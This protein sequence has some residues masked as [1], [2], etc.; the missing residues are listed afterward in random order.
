MNLKSFVLSLLIIWTCSA[1]GQNKEF[2]KFANYQDSLMHKAYNE[3]NPAD[4]LLSLNKFNEEY[5]RLSD[6]DKYYFR[7]FRINAIYNLSCTYSIINDKANALTYLKT[8]FEEGYNDLNHIKKD[9][10]LDNIRHEDAFLKIIEQYRTVYDYLYILK[11]AG[12]YNLQE[13]QE[14]PKFTYQGSG[15]PDLVRL[16]KAFKLDSVA[17]SGN[18]V[19]KIQNILHWV[20]NSIRHDGQHESGIKEVNA[21]AILTAVQTRHIGV[22][23]GEL[24]TVLK[25]CYLAMGWPARKVYCFPKDSLRTDNDSHVI[26]IVYLTSMHKWIWVDPT[27]DA[28]V[29]D[30]NGQLL[31]IEE[32]R[33]RLISDKPL[34]VN[35]DANYNHQQGISKDY[36]LGSYMAKNLYMVVCPVNSEFD[37]ETRSA[38]KTITYL[39][40]VPLDYHKKSLNKET[41]SDAATNSTQTN[42]W[43][44]NPA[45]FWQTPQ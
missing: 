29:M 42:Y 40:L 1:Y 27:N 28:Y 32:V 30:E 9:S 21:Y 23:C 5:S 14:I 15:S 34:F 22:C 39:R 37:C 13:K 45:I 16:R 18:E 17:G 24:A 3:K 6:M 33:N 19:S 41:W 26:D 11:K 10:D 2:V 12:R 7:G 31:S 38:G 43:T 25:D 20:H 44:N 36:Y 4:Y 35:A 8:S